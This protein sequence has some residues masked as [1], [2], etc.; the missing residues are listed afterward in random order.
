M[1]IYIIIFFA[2]IRAAYFS[3]CF[4]R[5]MKSMWK[6]QLQL[7]NRDTRQIVSTL[8]AALVH[9]QIFRFHF[10]VIESWWDTWT[11][12]HLKTFS[13]VFMLQCYKKKQALTLCVSYNVIQC[14]DSRYHNPAVRAHPFGDTFIHTWHCINSSDKL[15]TWSSKSRM[16]VSSL[17]DILG[18][19]K[20]RKITTEISLEAPMQWRKRLHR[21]RYQQV[22]PFGGDSVNL[23]IM[24]LFESNI[25]RRCVL[26]IW[27]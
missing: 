21:L 23:L 22:K 8:S 10:K 25:D 7:L 26:F 9:S 2:L 12:W 4:I 27:L 17:E 15:F 11:P 16:R 19:K 5:L 24:C 3:H 1:K 13:S 14:S 6:Q 20:G 18:L